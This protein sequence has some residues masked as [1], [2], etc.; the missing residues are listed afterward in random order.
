MQT[1]SNIHVKSASKIHFSLD[2]F[3]I[4]NSSVPLNILIWCVFTPN[5]FS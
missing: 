3:M 1:E 5:R 4:R 2:T